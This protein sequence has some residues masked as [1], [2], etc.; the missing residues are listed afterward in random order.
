MIMFNI[1]TNIKSKLRAQM[2][3]KVDLEGVCEEKKEKP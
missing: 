1:P 2:T 3:G